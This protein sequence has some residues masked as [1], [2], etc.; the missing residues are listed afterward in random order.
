MR[1]QH[2]DWFPRFNENEPIERVAPLSKFVIK[3]ASHE[4]PDNNTT[5]DIHNNIGI[6]SK[7]ESKAHNRCLHK[8]KRKH[9]QPTAKTTTPIMIH[10]L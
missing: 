3:K 9:I 6:G 7:P 5:G 8:N 2:L 4:Q 1:N 10:H